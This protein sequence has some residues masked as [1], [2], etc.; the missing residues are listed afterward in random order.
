[1]F[2][3]A[4]L[5]S[6]TPLLDEWPAKLPLQFALS[7]ESFPNIEVIEHVN[8]VYEY[9]FA[10]DSI[11]PESLAGMSLISFWNALEPDDPKPISFPRTIYGVL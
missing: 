9:L 4:L 1:M 2:T 11:G 7:P 5:W 6:S 3:S 10:T 8:D